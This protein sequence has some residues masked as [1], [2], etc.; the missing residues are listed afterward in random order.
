[1]S[2]A[3]CRLSAMNSIARIDEILGQ[4]VALLGRLG[5]RHLVVVVDQ[6]R[7][8]LVGV[9]PHEPVESL[10]AAAERPAVIGARGARLLGRR[11]VPLADGERVVALAQQDLGEK[12]VLE[13]D[14]PVSAGVAGR[15]FRD[16]GHRV[17]VVVA[18]REDAGA[19]RRTE[20]RGVHV[21][22]AQ[23]V[24][25]E[26]VEVGRPDRRAVAAEMPI[27]GVVEDDEEDVGRAGLRPNRLRPGRL[28]FTDRSADDARESRSLRVLLD[29]HVSSSSI[30]GRAAPAA[31]PT[32]RRDGG[33][34]VR[35]RR[36]EP[37]G[38]RSRATRTSDRAQRERQI[39]R[40]ANVRSRATRT[41]DRAQRERQIARTYGGCGAP[42]GVATI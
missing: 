1:M 37:A 24:R 26:A 4:V 18:P 42:A 35:R 14:Q 8:V 11:Q 36:K 41:S 2:G 3:T 5:G 16:A 38:V 25:G 6:V 9:A 29:R 31:P 28:R 19:A 20:R 39:A 13:G 17:R 23:P 7:V 10:E 33:R 15:P 34:R 12:A 30:L 32:W 21:G 27:P 40:N 22:E